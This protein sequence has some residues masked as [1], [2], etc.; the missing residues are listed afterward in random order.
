MWENALRSRITVIAGDEVDLELSEYDLEKGQYHLEI[1]HMTQQQIRLL[2][3]HCLKSFRVRDVRVANLFIGAKD[4]IE[5][6][7]CTEASINAWSKQKY[8][9]SK[10]KITHGNPHTINRFQL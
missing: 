3:W 4:G 7:E 6:P 10:D 8:H 9:E 5:C 2:C 1:Q